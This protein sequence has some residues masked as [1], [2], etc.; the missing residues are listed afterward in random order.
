MKLSAAAC[1]IG[2]KDPRCWFD[3]TQLLRK[4]E[5][6]LD[7]PFDRAIALFLMC[8]LA[9]HQTYFIAQ[10]EWYDDETK[11]W[12]NLGLAEHVIV[13]FENTRLDAE[14]LS[15]IES[16][17]VVKSAASNITKALELFKEIDQDGSGQLDKDEF[18]H[19]ME[20]MGE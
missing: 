4:F 18:T 17:R 10:S 11:T 12:V 19:L 6:R 13:D 1:N 16:L 9:A 3:S 8:L 20:C 14:Q 7:E 2:I 15:I 5:L